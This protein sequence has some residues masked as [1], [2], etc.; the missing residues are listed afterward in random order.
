MKKKLFAVLLA[1]VMAVGLLPTAAFAEGVDA[2]AETASDAVVSQPVQDD[3]DEDALTDTEPSVAVESQTDA[4]SAVVFAADDGTAVAE[5]VAINAANFPDA[6]F[7]TLVET[8]DTDGDGYLS[9]VELAAVTEIDAHNYGMPWEGFTSLKG[10][11]YFTSLKKLDCSNNFGL[12][13]LDVSKNTAL[14]YLD[15]GYTGITAL[16]ISNLTAL[17]HLA[18]NESK[19]TALDVSKNT[20]LT[21]LDCSD[22]NTGNS[23]KLSVLDVTNNKELTYLN[24]YSAQLSEMDVSQNTKL[25][26]LIFTGYRV[27]SLDVSHNPQ[28]EKL[29][30]AN[31]QVDKL[32]LSHNANLKELWLTSTKVSELDVSNNPKLEVLSVNKNKLTSLDVS[33]NPA[34]KQLYVYDEDIPCLDVSKCLNL[35]KL[36][37]GD[38]FYPIRLEDGRTFDL[39][40]IPGFNANRVMELDGGK[41]EGN[42]LIVDDGERL[43]EYKYDCDGT[44]K[45]TMRYYFEV[46]NPPEA[47]DHAYDSWKMD[48]TGHWQECTICYD[49]TDKAAHVYDNDADTICNV[50]GHVRTVSPNPDP[51]PAEPDY[52]FLDGTDSSFTQETDG[53]M[54]FHANGD[55]AKFTGVKVDGKLVSPEHYTVKE[56]STIVTLKN[57]FLATLSAGDHQ[58][59]VVYS[60]GDCSI[61][62]EVKAASADTGDK[63]DDTT[64]P[65]DTQKPDDTTK[66]DDTAK[67]GDTANGTDNSGTNSATGTNTG[68]STGANNSN[69]NTNTNTSAKSDKAASP[70]TA[71]MSHVFLWGALLIVSGGALTG[72]VVLKKKKY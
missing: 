10:I 7:R 54:T 21:Y 27:T 6:K 12:S 24:C 31:S 39:S 62:F 25:Q 9:E 65:D 35:G 20:A 70:K 49:E 3:A 13:E 32:D 50:C 2:E 64:K 37:V 15:C 14:T 66:P 42:T 23:D 5:G 57:E 58:L 48:D 55:L 1:L 46:E 19:M 41:V 51:T 67:P 47:H 59:T 44:G 68:T 26:T 8:F 30:I 53:T 16:D 22:M 11:A 4:D 34:L 69:S 29:D 56:G 36:G 71:D 40:T 17:T 63:S 28:L 33:H 18:C 52:K 43:L 38:G 45:F 61:D 72:A 60:D